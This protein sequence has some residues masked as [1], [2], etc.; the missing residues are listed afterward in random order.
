[1]EICVLL[2]V[3]AI[4]FLPIAMRL[5]ALNLEIKEHEKSKQSCEFHFFCEDGKC[6]RCGLHCKDWL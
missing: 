6:N 3:A 2:F 5:L 1:M 4:S